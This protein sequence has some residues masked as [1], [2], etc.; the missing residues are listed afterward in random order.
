MCRHLPALLLAALTA[1]CGPAAAQPGEALQ[2]GLFPFEGARA[3]VDGDTVKVKGLD[4]SLRLL[5]IDTE[6]TF[7]HDFERKAFAAGWEGYKQQMRHGAAR[8]VKMATPLGEEA[9]HFA[10]AFFTGV[11]RVKL[12]RDHPQEIR[13]YYGRYLAYVLVERDGQ[14]LNYNL[15]C[16]RAGMSPY[17]VK[18]GRSRRFH[19]LFVQAQETARAGQLG[20]WAPGAQHYDDYDERLVWWAE[21]EEA[22]RR[23]EAQQQLHPDSMIA[24]TR[25][26]ALVRLEQRVGQ[27]TV[28]LGSVQEVVELP[29]GPTVVKLAR[30]RVQSFDVVF[31]DHAVLRASGLQARKGEYVQV[32]GKISRYHDTRGRDHLQLVVASPGQVLRPSE[33]FEQALGEV[34]HVDGEGE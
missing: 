16:V 19:D 23:F 33:G 30:S 17:F 13:D 20:I 9:R 8:P 10:Q 32:R 14:W 25:S 12:E 15:E 28:L 3:V 26:D 27:E 24:L 31:F 6:E 4:A 5:G 18:Y 29:H 2:L 7:K 1:P 21:R 34:K 11:T 22:V